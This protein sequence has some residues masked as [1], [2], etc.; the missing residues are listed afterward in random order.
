MKKIVCLLLT[1]AMVFSLA[2]CGGPTESDDELI[3]IV[4]TLC[5]DS[6]KVNNLIFGE[7]I[8][9]KENGKTIG[10]YTEADAAS[11]AFYEVSAVS[12]IQRIAESVYT[13]AVAA[14]IK[15]TVLSS[16]KSEENGVVLTYARYYVG[17]VEDKDGEKKEIFLVNTSYEAT[18]GDA[19]YANYRI[20]EKKKETVSFLVDITVTHE[21]ESRVYTDQKITIYKE[22]HGWRLDTP[23]YATFN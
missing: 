10:S 4:K 22:Q 3:S 18:V 9:P 11:L 8:L 13:L 7:G 21:G 6:V 23:T 17:E 2:A 19:S 14:W 16:E 15:K 5:D 20:S 12:D 1:A